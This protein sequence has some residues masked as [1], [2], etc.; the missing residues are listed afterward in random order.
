MNGEMVNM[1]HCEAFDVTPTLRLIQPIDA[2]GGSDNWIASSR[3][4][5]RVAVHMVDTLEGEDEA[6]LWM[7][8]KR[9][10]R[11][12]GQ[13]KSPRI[14]QIYDQGFADNGRPFIVT[15]L[16][17]GE[18]LS[19]RIARLGPL[20]LHE[21]G[22]LLSQCAQA[23]ALAHRRDFVHGGLNADNVVMLDSDLMF[24]KLVDVGLVGKRHPR[25]DATAKPTMA[26][27]YAS[28]EQV[29]LGPVD[30]HSDLW[31]LAVLAYHALTGELPFTG[32]TLPAQVLSICDDTPAPFAVGIDNA[33]LDAWFDRALSKKP[34]RRFDSVEEMV[35][36]WRRATSASMTDDDLTRRVSFAAHNGPES[37]TN[38]APCLLQQTKS[39][40][41]DAADPDIGAPAESDVYV[42][43]ESDLL[44]EDFG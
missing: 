11:G 8:F 15:E 27:A 24:V 20:R 14:V 12:A 28:P 22:A 37:V 39:D 16:I 18:V 44:R 34:H 19:Q 41:V 38:I 5:G 3:P 32:R 21:V 35:S 6:E 26:H 13:L 25:L 33:E 43:G 17:D 4:L 31:S 30:H 9:Y 42:V 40:W 29:S 36:A 10:T 1:A 2:W 23:L 7:R